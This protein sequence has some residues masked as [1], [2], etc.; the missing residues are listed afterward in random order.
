M[1]IQVSMRTGRTLVLAVAG[2]V[3]AVMPAIALGQYQTSNST[4]RLLDA[5]NRLGSAGVNDTRQTTGGVSGDDII[6]GNVTRGRQFRGMVNETDARAF[7]GNLDT[8]SDNLVR[9]FGP[10]VYQRN[11][12]VDPFVAQRY[13][14]DS[15]GVR[16]PEGFQQLVPGSPGTFQVAKPTSRVPGDLRMD[17]TIP[18]PDM[19][20]PQPIQYITPS[21]TLLNNEDLDPMRGITGF[22]QMDQELMPSRDLLRRLDLDETRIREMRE[23]LR[24]SAEPGAARAENSRRRRT[25]MT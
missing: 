10:S 25:P 16:P 12:A 9:D 7:R 3:G 21:I 24:R 5:N 23:E 2:V 14:G 8:P 22:Q 19:S 6:Y 17:A 13:Y 4:G 1:S 15:R 20:V 18:N 11:A